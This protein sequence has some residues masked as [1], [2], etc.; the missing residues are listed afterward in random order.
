MWLPLWVS[1]FLPWGGQALKQVVQKGRGVSI[2]WGVQHLTEWSLAIP[3]H[4]LSDHQKVDAN[5]S[6]IF[7][8]PRM[9]ASRTAAGVGDIY[10]HA[11]ISERS[12]PPGM[13]VVSFFVCNAKGLWHLLDCFQICLCGQLLTI[14]ILEMLRRLLVLGKEVRVT[15]LLTYR[16]WWKLVETKTLH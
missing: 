1:F 11:G 8:Q 6:A 9:D 5:S 4:L 12:Q 3:Y 15:F 16:L 2:L 14:I 10:R 7:I 13:S